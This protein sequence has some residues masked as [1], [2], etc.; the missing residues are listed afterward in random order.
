[1][2]NFA[3]RIAWPAVMAGG[4]LLHATTVALGVPATLAAYAAAAMGAACVTALELSLPYRRSWRPERCEVVTDFVYLV[5][6]QTALPVALAL[7]LAVGAAGVL[8]SAGLHAPTLWPHEWPILAQVLAM[9]LLA[10][11]LRYAMHVAAHRWGPLWRLHAVHHAPQRLYWLNVARF[12]PLEK[13]LQYGLDALPFVLVGVAPEV[14]ALYFVF[15]A[16]NGFFQHSNVD[17]RLGALNYLVAGPELHRWHHSVHTAESNANYGNN[18]I[19]WDLLFGTRFLP[20]DRGVGE[21]G[22]HNRS[23]PMGLLAQFRAPFVRGL[24]QADVRV[25]DHF[26]RTP[27]LRCVQKGKGVTNIAGEKLYEGQVIEAVTGALDDL[28]LC[29]AF[30]VVLAV[31]KESRYRLLV[32]LPEGDP[33]ALA[34]RVDAE[35][36]DI[37]AEYGAKRKSGRLGELRVA[38]LR[39]GAAEANKRFWLKRGQREGQFKMLTLQQADDFAFEWEGWLR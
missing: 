35:L 19:V 17:V 15:Y 22:L 31:P 34:E 16:I 29:T 23:Y 18:L 2:A 6:V 11:L 21:L 4:L 10:D 32:E 13:A 37:N 33:E 3:S 1:M 7:T 36:A 38:A 26:E 9:L 25:T 30:F 39:D 27:T 24:D 20:S 28:D 14:L 5:L 8:A 12:H